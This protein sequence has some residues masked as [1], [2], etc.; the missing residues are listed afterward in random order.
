MSQ[1]DVYLAGAMTGRSIGEVLAERNEAK[2]ALLAQ[3]LTWYDPAEDEGLEKLPFNHIISNAFDKPRMSKYVSKDLA[4]VAE[5]R[6]VLNITGDLPSD[7]SLWE[8]SYAIFYR[9]I[10]VVLIAPERASEARMSFTNILVDGIYEDL[11]TAVKAVKLKI[12]E[13]R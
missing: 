10:P 12:Q 3:G 4:A 2:H 7:G 11:T 1:W 5:C 13:E 8:M 9:H 6:A